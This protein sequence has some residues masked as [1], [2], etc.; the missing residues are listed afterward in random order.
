[1]ILHKTH[2]RM[3][4]IDLINTLDI[5][6]I[7]NFDDNKKSIHGKFKDLLNICKHII[8]YCNSGYIIENSTYYKDEQTIHDDVLYISQ[9]GDIPSSR[10]ACKL[11]NAN[12]INKYNYQPIISPQMIKKLEDKK[13][14]KQ[15]KNYSAVFR[16]GLF[17][18][19]FD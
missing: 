10:R 4:L 14:T 2:S 8:N 13:L 1:M 3:D 7:F 5:P 15:G 9:F 17:L 12:Y 19:S 11:M 6:I 16:R 18:I